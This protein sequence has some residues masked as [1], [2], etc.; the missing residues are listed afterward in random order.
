M[1][2]FSERSG[3]ADGYGVADLT[4]DLDLATAPLEVVRETLDQRSLVV[5]DWPVRPGMEIAALLGLVEFG[6]DGY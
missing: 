1:N 5:G 2:H 6:P 3:E 4:T